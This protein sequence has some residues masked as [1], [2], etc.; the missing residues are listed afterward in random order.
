MKPPR[1]EHG[2][3]IQTGCSVVNIQIN[4]PTLTRTSPMLTRVIVAAQIILTIKYA[5]LAKTFFIFTFIAPSFSGYFLAML[6]FGKI[7]Q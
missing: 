6:W 5:M 7:L 1:I 3:E 4:I 2:P